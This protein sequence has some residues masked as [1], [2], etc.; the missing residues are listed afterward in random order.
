MLL[1]LLMLLH[2][3]FCLHLVMLWMH[4]F[5]FCRLHSKL[6]GILEVCSGWSNECKLSSG[7]LNSLEEG[8]ACQGRQRESP[9]SAKL[10]LK[11]AET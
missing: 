9:V 6:N 8:Q 11:D 5:A 1:H 2:L 7:G 3:K 4:H 10:T